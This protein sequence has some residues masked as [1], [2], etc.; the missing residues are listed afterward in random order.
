MNIQLFLIEYQNIF[1]FVMELFD[2]KRRF[3]FIPC[4][5]DGYFSAFNK[6]DAPYTF[7]CIYDLSTIEIYYKTPKIE[8]NYFTDKFH[9]EEEE[10]KRII[11]YL[12]SHEYGHSFLVDSTYSMKI[13]F[14]HDIPLPND[15]NFIF[16]TS[17]YSE[18]SADSHAR[19]IFT[20]HPK[21]L[22]SVFLERFEERL[23]YL[24]LYQFK[25]VGNPPPEELNVY[26]F[27]QHYFRELIRIFV[28]GKWDLVIPLFARNNMNTFQI[29]C[30]RLFTAFNRI[31]TKISIAPV[32]KKRLVD[33]AEIIAEIRFYDIVT[34][35]VDK[36]I[37]DKIDFF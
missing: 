33:L 15:F 11:A 36:K 21:I 26:D 18:F 16:L 29:F 37:L 32:I 27:Y 17:M 31:M 12:V 6:K 19:S 25:F 5:Q 34:N 14:E 8:E 7:S 20:N 1:T 28:F 24:S 30:E 2:D 10:Y 4:N 13:L 9:I 22:V 35:N 23:R 3:G